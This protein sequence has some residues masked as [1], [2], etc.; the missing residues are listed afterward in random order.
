MRKI[1][2]L[3]AIAA[4]ALLSACAQT[5]ETASNECAA[6]T[7]DQ[8][9][10]AVDAGKCELDVETAAGGTPEATN[11]P[12]KDDHADHDDDPTEPGD[13]PD[14]EPDPE[15]E[16]EDGNPGPSTEPTEGSNSI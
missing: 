15:P 1:M 16:R 8:L 2:L 3:S 5:S 11:S 6:L 9:V 10:A 7:A 12:D 4:A 14:P 13:T